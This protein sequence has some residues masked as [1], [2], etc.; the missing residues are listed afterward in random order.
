MIRLAFLVFLFP[1]VLV[2]VWDDAPRWAILGAWIV[3]ALI[4]IAP[5]VT[6][7]LALRCPAC[8]KRIKVGYTTCHHCGHAITSGS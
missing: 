4:V 5:Y 7:Q 1:L 2:L 8:G 6:G 3:G